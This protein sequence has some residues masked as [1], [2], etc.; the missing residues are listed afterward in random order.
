[1]PRRCRPLSVFGSR[2]IVPRMNHAASCCSSMV[3]VGVGVCVGLGVLRARV[4]EL[5]RSCSLMAGV[6]VDIGARVRRCV[7]NQSA[8]LPVC[9]ACM[10]TKP[11]LFLTGDGT[12]VGF[13]LLACE[14]T[15]SALRGME[16]TKKMRGRG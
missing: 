11:L 12:R 8:K 16:V 5:I 15:S 2:W 9:T 10:H 13:I 4:R 7:Y 14:E 3:G 6:T 1:M